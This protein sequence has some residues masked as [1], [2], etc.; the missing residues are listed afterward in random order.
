[1]LLGDVPEYQPL[2]IRD[3]LPVVPIG[4]THPYHMIVV[5]GQECPTES[6]APRG[7]GGGLMKGMKLHGLHSHRK[8]KENEKDE[9]ARNKAREDEERDESSDSSHGGTGDDGEGASADS[10]EGSRATTPVL[11]S[12]P[13]MHRHPHPPVRGWSSMLDGE[14]PDGFA[15][16]LVALMGRLPVRGCAEINRYGKGAFGRY[17]GRPSTL[18]QSF[19]GRSPGHAPLCLGAYGYLDIGSIRSS[20]LV[21]TPLPTCSLARL[22]Y[23]IP[24]N[25]GQRF[26]RLRDG[27]FLPKS[28]SDADCSHGGRDPPGRPAPDYYPVG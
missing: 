11:S 13:T 12:T 18:T 15:I 1:V 3:G 8:G 5:A 23:F 24:L 6:G 28:S 19:I 22:V 14:Y 4:N 17:S 20:D 21:S 25:V 16:P 27:G 26:Q 2:E 10:L 7:I 9:D